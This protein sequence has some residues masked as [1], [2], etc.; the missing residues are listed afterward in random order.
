MGGTREE[1]VT[2]RWSR[3]GGSG[4]HFGERSQGQD[5]SLGEEPGT[6]GGS[7]EKKSRDEGD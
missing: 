3:L 7:R 2:A 5:D 4:L 1:H 6:G